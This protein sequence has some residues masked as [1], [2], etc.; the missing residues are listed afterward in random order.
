[1]RDPGPGGGPP[2]NWQ[3]VFGGPA[4]EWDPATGQYY[5]HSFLA[6]QPDLNWR[7][8]AVRE[9]M[10]GVMRFWLD[11]GVDGFRIDVADFVMKD[12]DLGDDPPSDDYPPWRA[13]SRPRSRAHP[14][15]HRVFREMR[16]LLD[17]CTPPRV[18]VGEIHEADLAV[19]CSYYGDGD[20]PE[21]HLPFNFSLLRSPWDAAEVRR[22]VEDLEAALPSGAWPNYVL[23]NHDEPRL[24]TRVGEPAARVAA[25]LLLT[26]R[27]TPTL[28]NGDELGL[29]Q[30]EVPPERQQDPF[31]RRVPGRGRD[32]CR[33]PMP[34]DRT[35][36]SGFCP[37]GAMPWLPLG[38]GAAPRSVAA[39]LEDP[40]SLLNL[41]RALLRLR[42][43]SP[44]LRLGS[45]GTI[46]GV[47]PGCFAFRRLHPGSPALTV[48]LNFTAEP[49]R[50]NG[51]PAGRIALATGRHRTGESVMGALSLGPH[52][53]VV[54]EGALGEAPPEDGPV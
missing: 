4:W 19:W 45:Y 13:D 32:G 6:E 41:Y 34:W 53:G 52:E 23:G 40:G 47:P 5:L 15:V 30:L 33:T 42:R 48:A 28:Y 26:L 18:A 24:A 37:P 20:K 8:P 9:A 49:L 10:Y 7:H 16:V 21:L 22:R 3:A 51:L 46:P 12:P 50:V 17:G 27:G 54:L 14:D 36:N 43:G 39:Q 25:M 44:A 31:G 2:N 29:P 1:W 35:P 38:A 11:R